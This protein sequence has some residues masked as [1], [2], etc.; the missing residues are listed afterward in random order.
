MNFEDNLV[1]YGL[2]SMIKVGHPFSDDQRAEA[3]KLAEKLLKPVTT[4]NAPSVH[5]KE[6]AALNQTSPA[7]PQWK[8]PEGEGYLKTYA[9]DVGQ[10]L[11]DRYLDALQGSTPGKLGAAQLKFENPLVIE[12]L[13]RTLF[14]QEKT[15][16]GRVFAYAVV[17]GQKQAGVKVVTMNSTPQGE[18]VLALLPVGANAERNAVLFAMAGNVGHL[19]LTKFLECR[20]ELDERDKGAKARAEICAALDKVNKSDAPQ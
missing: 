12:N 1:I 10:E 15:Q 17:V 3:G 8:A 19:F 4:T 2:L 9:F 6:E 13:T 16:R 14:N 7:F 18:E 20:A 11:V 5:A